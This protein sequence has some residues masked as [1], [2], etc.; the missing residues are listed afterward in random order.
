MYGIYFSRQNIIT[1]ALLLIE[2][3]LIFILNYSLNETESVYRVYPVVSFA[4]LF[5]IV[6]MIR[7][8]NSLKP[9]KFTLNL[10]VIFLVFTSIIITIQHQGMIYNIWYSYFYY[11]ITT[12]FYFL[13]IFIHEVREARK[14]RTELERLYEKLE[15]SSYSAQTLT[16]SAEKKLERV[17]AFI[18]EN[19]TSDISREGLAAAV[20]MNPNY[21]SQLF[22][23]YTGKK[24]KEYINHLR[25]KEAALR[26]AGADN[27]KKVID[28]ALAV[29]FESLATF[30]RAFKS[31]FKIT[32]TE[33]K[34]K[35]D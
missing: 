28:I 1:G 20:D 19:F 9:D 21:M 3:F 17:I 27:E 4:F 16:E 13:F 11:I 12:P 7:R 22:N 18:D 10:I 31:I 5:Y 29:G 23:L 25:I 34:K 14:K 2:S 33:Y 24:I 15:G 26:L 30:N 6:Y 8:L 35:L 32:P